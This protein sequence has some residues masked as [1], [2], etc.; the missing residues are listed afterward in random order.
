MKPLQDIDLTKNK[1]TCFACNRG[2]IEAKHY[3]LIR[4]TWFISCTECGRFTA[5][6]KFVSKFQWASF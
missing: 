4:A 5:D 3:D 2:K 6:K 1:P